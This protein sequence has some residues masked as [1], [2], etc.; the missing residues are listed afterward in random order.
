MNLDWDQV[1]AFALSLSD[2]ETA[3]HYGAPSVKVNGHAIISPGREPGSFCL[4]I[5]RDTVD[6]LKDTDPHTYW[7][8]PHYVG[9]PAV[10][11]RYDTNDP[12]RV[13]HMIEAAHAWNAARPKSKARP[14]KA[15]A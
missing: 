4:I 3:S 13:L 10:L 15:R 1:V 6:M 2:T 12:E 9:W 8:T 14:R 11:V 5:D 7:Q